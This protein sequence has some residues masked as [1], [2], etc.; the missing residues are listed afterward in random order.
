MT[1]NICAHLAGNLNSKKKKNKSIMTRDGTANKGFL[2]HRKKKGWKMVYEAIYLTET[3][4]IIDIVEKPHVYSQSEYALIA[5]GFITLID[6]PQ[7]IVDAVDNPLADIVG[8]Y[9]IVA[10]EFVLI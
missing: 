6:V 7:A 3:G 9:K 4:M 1:V 10:G 2:R 8:V 5:M